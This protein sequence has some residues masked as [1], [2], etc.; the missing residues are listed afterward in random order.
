MNIDELIRDSLSEQAAAQ[1]RPGPAFADRALSIQRRRSSRALASL[2]AA[3]T[4]MVGLCV[5]VP[6]LDPVRNSAS[7]PRDAPHPHFSQLNVPVPRPA[8]DASPLASLQNSGDVI[9]HPDQSPPHDLIAAGRTALAAYYTVSIV[10][11]NADEGVTRRTYRILDQKTGTYRK[12]TR[13][14]FVDVAPGMRTAAVLERNL[15]VKRIGL[16]DLLTGKI[17]SWIPLDRGVASVAF[18]PDGGRLVATT[19]ATDPDLVF[20]QPD[21][22]DGDG[23]SN[24]WFPT[25][26]GIVKTDQT[27]RTGFYILSLTSGRGSWSPA[28]SKS[29]RF[30]IVRRD[31]KFSADG[32]LVHTRRF[33][34]PGG[35]QH[36]DFRGNKVAAPTKEKY[37]PSDLEAGLS[38]NGKLGAGSNVILDSRTGKQIHHI[39][40]KRAIAWADNTRV[41]AWDSTSRNEFHNRLVLVPIDKDEILPLSGFLP[42]TEEQEPGRWT[43]LFAER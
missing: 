25:E 31:F 6:T 24:D 23:Q 34:A 37:T 5:T 3:T 29:D 14:S 32:K 28:P 8:Q 21:D 40:G 7:S 30:G 19:Y 35:D 41:I 43:P 18:S 12:D 9:A 16:L 20:R 33:T 15:P 26:N 38:P 10:K 11:Q 22:A 2:A 27:K 13:W 1:Q 39:P 17:E 4:I 36:Y 42:G